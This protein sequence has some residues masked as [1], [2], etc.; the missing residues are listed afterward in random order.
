MSDDHE[1]GGKA[2]SLSAPVAM[3]FGYSMP[4]AASAPTG[5]ETMV[6]WG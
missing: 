1:K 3:K 2:S 6:S 4:P 5:G